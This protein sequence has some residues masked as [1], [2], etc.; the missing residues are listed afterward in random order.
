MA[1]RSY[2]ELT[3]WQKAM[4]LAVSVYAATQ[5]WPKEEAY[6]LTAQVRR[7]VVSIPSN[8]AEGQGRYS[9][10]EFARFLLIA[11]G[12]LCELE[13]QILLA[14]RLAYLDEPIEQSLLLQSAEVGRLLQGLIR[15]MRP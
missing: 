5:G 11:H 12:S 2:R 15:S 14:R 4:D 9:P 3:A 6:G 10:K 8:V 7:A 13:T 1:V